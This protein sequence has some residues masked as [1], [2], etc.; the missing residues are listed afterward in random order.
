MKQFKQFIAEAFQGFWE[1]L[2]DG[3][4]V[5]EKHKDQKAAMKWAKAQGA[6][7]L[8]KV[9]S[10]GKPVGKP[11][12]VESLQEYKVG[13]NHDRYLRVHGKKAKGSGNWAFSTKRMG[14]PSDD[15][16]VFVSGTLKAAAKEAMKKLGSKEVYVMEA[17]EYKV[18]DKLTYTKK[19]KKR[20]GKII[21]IDQKNGD[22][23]Y[24]TDS[25]A[26]VYKSDLN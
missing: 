23:R 3:E 10:T 17:I 12:K 22:T 24:E 21:S 20:V 11:I 2:V 1:I 8:L 15:E 13:I 18:G 7:T 19:N 4:A 5:R 9:T 16:I 26:Y 14:D 6:K 25:G